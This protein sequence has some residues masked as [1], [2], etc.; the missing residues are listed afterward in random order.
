LISIDFN[1]DSFNP[2]AQLRVSIFSWSAVSTGEEH[3][4]IRRP[5][6]AAAPVQK[7]GPRTNEDI[8][9]REV[10][11]IDKDGTNRGVTPI[12]DAIALARESGLDLVEISPNVSPPVCKILDYGK[13]K[14]QAQKK[15]AEARKKQK[16]VEVK[17]IKLRPGIDKHDYEVKMRSMKRFFEEGDKVKVTLRFRGREMAHQELGY[18]LL[19]RVRE[20]T[21]PIAKVEAE[22]MSEG[23]QI[24]MILAPR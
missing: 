1:L 5:M 21:G 17:E 13:F 23:R 16:T 6:R 9:V 3:T 20:D 7:D 18:K 19:Q 4:A 11:L 22:P 10:Q 14:Y 24:V 8:R 15:A 12:N 2:P